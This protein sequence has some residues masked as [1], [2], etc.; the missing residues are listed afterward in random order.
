[1]T[2]P[3][4]ITPKKVRELRL[5]STGGQRRPNVRLLC[6][7][8]VLAGPLI[9]VLFTGCEREG[10]QVYRVAKEPAQPAA[11]QEAAPEQQAQSDRPRLEWT[12][13]NGWEERPASAMRV[14][15][16]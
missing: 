7:L 5:I 1:M 10:I 16:F 13:P 6:F 2:R 14:A 11:A 3:K 8:P 4:Q 9:A 15:S 12:L